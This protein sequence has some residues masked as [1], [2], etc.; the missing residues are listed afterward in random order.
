MMK[1]G[2][3]KRSLAIPLL[4]III[5]TI[6]IELAFI[7]SF[8]LRFY[9]PL[10]EIIPPSK[11]IP[12]FIN[13]FYFSIFL[14][15]TYL[16]LFSI[17][18]SYR[19]RLFNNFSQD[20]PVIFKVSFLGIIFGMSGAFLYRGFSYSRLVFIL[21]LIISII[22]LMLG[23]SF[24]H[25]IKNFFIKK[26][27]DV[28]KVY[29]VG[30]ATLLPKITIQLKSSK[31]QTFDILG[32]SAESE[33]N[34]L[35]IPYKGD[36][37]RVS[38]LINHD[39]PDGLVLAFDQYDYYKI[40][41]IIKLTEGKNIELFYIPD[42]LDLLTSNFNTLEVE[43]IL[44]LQLKAF[45]LSGW[46]GFIKRIFDILISILGIIILV[47]FFLLIALFI[48]L[49]SRG[50]IFY[51]QERIGMDG[52]EFDII[53]FRSMIINAEKETGPTWA[54]KDD[55][56]VTLLGKF[57][58]RTSLDELPQLINVVRGDMSLV[59][60]RPERPHFV[61]EFRDNI[62]KYLERHRVR[63]GIT[64]WAQVNGLRGQSPIEERTKYDIYYIENWSLWFDIKIIILTFIAIFKGE[65]AY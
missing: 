19:T 41:E 13:Y 37:T 20:I 60:P 11:G 6:S 31:T 1:K 52:N 62:P 45:T 61:Q 21:I 53:K 51:L 56:R 36:L 48:K 7:F 3:Y 63:S 49:T 43:G 18:R 25:K 12:L 50:P 30:S 14:L 65:N 33:I 39:A 17:S 55:T 15:I 2:V 22:F 38:Q 58:R 46:Q 42:I 47:P 34:D 16:I 9:S 35:P 28:L 54:K 32:Y 5:D 59:G 10:T 26:G 8:W 64:G 23:R 40:G 44:L 29:L 27:F 24:F 4:K 57:I